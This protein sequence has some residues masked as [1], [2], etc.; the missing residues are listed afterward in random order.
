MTLSRAVDYQNRKSYGK[1]PEILP[2][3]NLIQTQL[4]SYV[5]FQHEGLKELLKNMGIKQNMQ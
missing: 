4:D 1:L 5:W 2:V 3:P